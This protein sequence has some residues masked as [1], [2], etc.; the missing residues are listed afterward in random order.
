MALSSFEHYFKNTTKTNGTNAR[1][2]LTSTP[3]NTTRTSVP[4]EHFMPETQPLTGLSN[5]PIIDK[6]DGLQGTQLSEWMN[7]LSQT[8]N[9]NAAV[10]NAL[11][12]NDI[13]LLK[14]IKEGQLSE[15]VI[16]SQNKSLQKAYGINNSARAS[17]LDKAKAIAQKITT[18]YEGGDL[19]GNFDGQGLS[20]GYLQWNIGSQTAQPM[21]KEMANG[22]KTKDT[23]NGIFSDTVSHRTTDGTIVNITMA[24]ALRDILSRSKSE[25]L[26]WARSINDRN[27]Q[28]VE[29]WK[30]AFKALTKNDEFNKIEDQFARPYLNTATKIMNNSDYGVKTVRG[31]ALAF[32]IAVQNGSVKASAQKLIKEAL[33]GETNKLTNPNHSGLTN[34][35]RTVIKDLKQ[36]LAGVNDSET[37]KLYYTAAAVAISSNDRFVRDVWSRKV[38]IV[39]GSGKVHGTLHNLN[40]NAGLNDNTIA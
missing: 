9:L 34:N 2:P 13:S 21:L 24:E 26:S 6:S 12:N 20:I 27:N 33:S 25:Q 36:R 8:T 39:S 10:L 18:L 31:Y 16:N 7:L 30:S 17:L 15:S 1:V 40:A 29:P 11:E 19:T 5:T 35:Q 22:I 14:Q 37:R 4:F 23:F 3:K 38:A 32:D 28:I